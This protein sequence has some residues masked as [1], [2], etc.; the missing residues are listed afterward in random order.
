MRPRLPEELR[1]S[2]RGRDLNRCAYCHSPE[3]LSVAS[4]EIDHIVP[5]SAGGTTQPDNLC[6]AC[7][8]CNRHKS[9]RLSAPDPQSGNDAQVF[10]PRAQNWHEHFSWNEDGV[11][12][13][14]LTATGRATIDLLD[15]NRERVLLLR[16]LWAK[17]G[18][19][20]W[21]S[22]SPSESMGESV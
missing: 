1:S 21:S 8:N 22:Q 18:I 17:L 5:L 14:G 10:H 9:S 7:P 4:F 20:P 19:P 12:L 16:R 2:I 3:M 11:T 15:L 13:V 6:L